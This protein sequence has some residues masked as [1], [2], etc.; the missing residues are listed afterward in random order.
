M[1]ITCLVY[2]ILCANA[3]AAEVSLYDCDYT[4]SSA[5]LGQQIP[6]SSAPMPGRT[7][8]GEIVFG[9]VVIGNAPPPWSG[10]AAM[11]RPAL[12]GS[13]LYYS[14]MRFFML[15]GSVYAFRKHRIETTFQFPASGVGDALSILTDGGV[16][17][18]LSFGSSGAVG[19]DFHVME[20]DVHL[21]ERLVRKYQ[22]LSPIDPSQPV[23]LIWETDID[24]GK[25]TVTINGNQTTVSGLSPDAY[26]IRN[27]QLYPGPIQVRLNFSSTGTTRHLGLRSIRITGDDYDGPLFVAPDAGVSENDV[28]TVPF[29]APASGTWQPQFSI[30]GTQWKNYG[31]PIGP[32]FPFSSISF[33]KQVSPSMFFRLGRVAE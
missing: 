7:A 18:A 27:W 24:G 32:D 13:A 14:Q 6:L 9:D 22:A 11:M 2:G 15:S 29:V 25:T 3:C 31:Q 17:Y 8:C 28:A 26:G 5:L 1:K 10:T 33:G 19:L 21:G 12:T 20:T 30:D 16:T 4:A 23:H